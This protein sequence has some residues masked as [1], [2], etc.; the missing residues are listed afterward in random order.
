MNLYLAAMKHTNVVISLDTRRK[1]FD[2]AYP[3]IMRLG[4]FRRTTSL[5]LGISLKEKDWDDK[6]KVVKR[7][8]TGTETVSRLNN[9][10]QKKRADAMD[11]ILKLHESGILSTLSVAE[12]RSRI[13]QKD[14]SPS[15]FDFAAEQI[16]ALRKANRIG[17]AKSYEGTV[18]ALK[19]YNKGRPVAKR[20][21]GPR[22]KEANAWD[23]RVQDL[24][25]SEITYRFLVG[26]EN[27]HLA[28]GNQL[29]G[30]AVYMR[31]IRAIFNKG[32]KSGV[33]EEELYPFEQY[34]IRTAPTEK[35]ALESEYIQKIV[36][37]S[38]DPSHPCFHARNYFL[39][40]YM[41]YGMNF[42]DMACLKRTDL[43]NGRIFYR[44]NKTGKLYDI[45]VTGGLKE[46]LD[47]YLTAQPNPEYIFP[48]VNRNTPALM[49]KDIQWARKRY[50]QK[51]K[52]IAQLCGIESNLTSYVSRHSF[53]TQAMLAEVPMNA[54]SAMLGHSSLKTTE[55]YLKSLPSNVLDE[56]NSRIVG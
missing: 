26:F 54:I 18:A 36:A 25:F 28:A 11:I 6:A 20:K 38:L 52:E 37:L 17:T 34:K 21:G 50:N 43:R 22:T 49:D 47:Y 48:I 40:S 35:R 44:R 30:L 2:G 5:P 32:I 31:T 16:A 41:M 1:R 45:R 10:I 12:L 42:K 23:D 55:I 24:K 14:Q 46:I 27:Y 13:D 8:Y 3:L 9:I 39:A 53:A 56:Y 19:T 33:V 4:H 51:L 15:F 29:N 7:S